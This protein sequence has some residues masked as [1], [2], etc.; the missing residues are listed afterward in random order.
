VRGRVPRGLGL[1]INYRSRPVQAVKGFFRLA[2]APALTLALALTGSGAVSRSGS[3]HTV[4]ESI[5]E[6][7]II[8]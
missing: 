3:T 1:I 5:G 6:H 8:C 2:L 7:S 4:R